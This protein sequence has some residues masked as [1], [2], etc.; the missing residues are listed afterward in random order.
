MQIKSKYSILFFTLLITI[1]LSVS[2]LCTKPSYATAIDS[3][4]LT[5]TPVFR[6]PVVR[7]AQISS[8]FDHHLQDHHIVFY[9]GRESWYGNGFQFTCPEKGN[10]WVGC[11]IT[12]NNEQ[13]CPNSSELWYDTPTHKGVDYE[14]EDNWHTGS[15][16]DLDRFA[17][18]TPPPIFFPAIRGKVAF[19]QYDN[20]YNGNAIFIKHDL[21]NNSNFEDD[22]F[23]SVYLHF[24]SIES[25]IRKGAT[26]TMGQMLGRGGM[27][28]LAW[29]PHLHFEVQRASDPSFQS[30]WSV[31]PF[32]WQGLGSDPWPHENRWLWYYLTYLPISMRDH[33]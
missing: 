22:K 24:D 2:T 32:G 9:D 6:Y 10:A 5:P 31:D 7:N 16:C 30:K 20:P 33:Q 1:L 25:P 3:I 23:R 13:S 15:S 18:F 21:N 8:M 29:T 19:V 11:L 27:T 28:G 4:F 26:V 12:A 14:Y 17:N